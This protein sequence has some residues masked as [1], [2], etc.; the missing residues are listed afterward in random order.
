M[1][2]VEPCVDV[3]DDDGRAAAGDRVRLGRED[4]AHVPLQPRKVVGV[5]RW[6]A[7]RQRV[8]CIGAV[9]PPVRGAWWR[10]SRLPTR[11]RSSCFPTVSRRTLPLSERASATPIWAVAVDEA[12][13]RLL[14]GARGV[15]RDGGSLVED[16]VVLG[17]AGVCAGRC[18][19]ERHCSDSGERGYRRQ[20]QAFTYQESPLPLTN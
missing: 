6:G 11:P 14:D 19:C 9:E 8:T 18:H 12:A 4:L 15:R 13:A 10:I 20:K 1:R 7:V 3:A 17:R 2:K 16:E 5:G